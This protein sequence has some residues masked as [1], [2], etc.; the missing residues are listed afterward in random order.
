MLKLTDSYTF[1]THLY[2]IW[3]PM[4]NS[5]NYAKVVNEKLL[6]LDYGN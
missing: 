2:K 4:S 3:H 6:L 5:S 1:L